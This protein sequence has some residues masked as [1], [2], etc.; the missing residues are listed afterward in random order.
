MTD[1]RIHTAQADTRTRALSTRL[2]LL[3]F[4]V[5]AALA[6]VAGAVPTAQA[7]A[8]TVFTVNA[9]ADTNDGSCDPLGQG[10]G[11]KDC[12][13]REAINAA[14]N[15]PNASTDEADRDQIEFAIPQPDPS[16]KWV[17]IMP[18]SDLP[19]ISD[20]VVIDGKSECEFLLLQNCAT[21][22]PLVEVLSPFVP[23]PLG[24]S[25][26]GFLLN[27]GHTM[28]QDLSIVGFWV[29]IGFESLNPA[30][31]CGHN[32]FER[33]YIGLEP[34]GTVPDL[35]GRQPR[36]A[37]SGWGQDGISSEGIGFPGCTDCLSGN[38]FIGNVIAGIGVRLISIEPGVNNNV[39][40][41]NRL[42]T[43]P[44]GTAA[45]DACCAAD[46]VLNGSGNLI[47]GHEH[48]TPDVGC[49]GECNLV[50]GFSQ[51]GITIEPSV[52]VAS[53][54][55]DTIEGN[56]VGTD[57]TGT[58][59]LAAPIVPGGGCGIC[60]DA[61]DSRIGGTDPHQRNLISVDIG[62]PGRGI[63]AGSGATNLV[64]EGN[65]I[66][67]DISGTKAIE[68]AIH[69]SVGIAGDGSPSGVRIGGTTG[70]DTPTCDGA[71]NL[72]SGGSEG[73]V[74]GAVNWTIE[75]NYIGTDATGTQPLPNKQVDPNTAAGVSLAGLSNGTTIGG[76]DPAAGNLIAYNDG[77]GVLIVDCFCGN[78]ILSNRIFD[79]RGTGIQLGSFPPINL[80]DTGDGDTGP[81]D[82]QNYP[83]I[84]DVSVANGETTVTGTFNSRANRAYHL[85]F[86]RNLPPAAD[87]VA[88]RCDSLVRDQTWCSSACDPWSFFG[89]GEHLIETDD[90]M[91]DD[92]GNKDFSYTFPL[93]SRAVGDDHGDRDRRRRQ[94]HVGVL[95]V[96]GGHLDREDGLS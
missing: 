37:H 54:S 12:T 71:C 73:I 69:L 5:F 23:S 35:L 66:G 57:I 82:L 28:I 63:S 46:L 62:H 96:P 55:N 95:A 58:K 31:D 72:I 45:V 49:S 91:T 94:R 3:A 89:E 27:A 14:N 24:T 65:Y 22:P 25:L 77:V 39:I 33:N 84:T 20:P 17:T 56:F 9:T 29:D 30:C 83:V 85:Q 32:V 8:Y 61:T 64:I 40:Q 10:T 81:N 1:D 53:S 15:H 36:A 60:I 86:F 18:Q 11:N 93:R 76:L 48:T 41:G 51:F 38:R 88:R 34:N 13:L 59:V 42:G 2:G 78:A 87:S 6:F 74:G 52:G 68:P 44:D 16:A 7:A 47:G 90:V 80:N 75:G 19:A 26:F 43:T 50:S 21:S 67:T 70:A 4:A 79:N 92:A